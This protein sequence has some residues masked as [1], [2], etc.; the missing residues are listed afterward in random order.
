LFIKKQNRASKT[1][2]QVRALNKTELFGIKNT[3]S[4]RDGGGE[5]RDDA[6]K[7]G[8]ERFSSF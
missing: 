4:Q 1:F 6:D 2:S 8:F 3:I 7:I 5:T